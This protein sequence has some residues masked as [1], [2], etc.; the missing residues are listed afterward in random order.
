MRNI[1]YNIP[2][3]KTLTILTA[4]CGT[5]CLSGCFTV[6]TS[7]LK[8][9][10]REHVVMNNYGWKFFDWVPLF[11]GNATEGSWWAFVMFRDDVTMEKIQGRFAKY[12]AGREIECPVYDVNDSSF[13]SIFGIPI[14][15]IITYNKITLSGTLK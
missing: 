7:T 9:S 12:A 1:L 5:L 11:C 4:L 3:M 2:H 8:P 13:I 10:G 6:D 14:P 15:Y